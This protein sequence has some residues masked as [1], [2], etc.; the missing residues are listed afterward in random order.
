MEKRKL[1][2]ASVADLRLPDGKSDY[3]FW[4]SEVPGFGVRLRPGKTTWIIQYRVG[5]KQR[6][7]TLGDVKTLNGDKARKAAKDRLAQ[8][9]LGGDPQADKVEARAKSAIT[10]GSKVEIYLVDKEKT[11][12]HNTIRGLKGYLRRHWKPLHAIPLD[13]ITRADV[14]NRIAEME[15][16]NGQ[17]AAGHARSALSG[18]FAWAISKGLCDVN[19]VVGTAKPV[20]RPP[21]ERTLSGDEIR[22]VWAACRDDDFGKIIKLAILLGCREDEIAGLCWSELDL[23]EA[24]WKIP[25]SRAKGKRQHVVALSRTA[26]DIIK[27][28]PARLGRDLLFGSGAG[29]FAGFSRAKKSLDK[30][31]ADAWG[32]SLQPW[33]IH[34]LRRT[35]ATTMG[36]ELGILPHVVSEILGHVGTHK[37]GVAG[38]Y[39]HATYLPDVSR[40]MALWDD[41]VRAIVTDAPRKFARLRRKA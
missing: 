34:D 25:P 4:D 18:F 11:S 13:R 30:R 26:I 16:R 6:R 36:N 37:R 28:I 1:T 19:P 12:R 2:S 20:T 38:V 32:A 24:R 17:V 31:I 29:P 35:L 5:V 39:N 22:A 3:I 33:H 10:L 27:E 9:R 7:H 21:R 15:T 14:S 40:A 8:V 41:Y 23:T